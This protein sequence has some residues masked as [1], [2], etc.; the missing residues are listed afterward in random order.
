MKISRRIL[1]V[2]LL[3]SACWSLPAQERSTTDLIELSLGFGFGFPSASELFV[4]RGSGGITQGVITDDLIK[5]VF[6]QRKLVE[7]I[8]L[9]LDYDSDRQGG[10]FDGENIYSLQYLGLEHEF[11]KEISVGNRYLSIPDTRLFPIDEGNT[12]SY[13]LRTALSNDR[14]GIQG[15]IRYSQAL[16]GKKRFRGSSQLVE[17]EALDVNYVKRRFYFLPDRDI[18]ESS[19]LLYSSSEVPKDVVVDGKD[20]SLLV[21][22][23]DY[24]F[25]NS[26][27]RIYLQHALY[28]EDELIVYYEQG[29]SAVGSGLPLGQQAIIDI[30]GVRD[31]F[32]ESGYGVYFGTDGGTSYLYLRK[33]GLDSYW[34]I[35]SAYSLAEVYGDLFPQEVEVKILSTDTGVPNGNYDPLIDSYIVDADYGVLIFT[36]EDGTDFYPRPFPAE[37][38]YD[39]ADAPYAVGDPRNP[40]DPGHPIYDEAGGPDAEDSVNT[41]RISYAVDSGS[42]FL[43]FDII[44]G[45]VRVTVDGQ[46]LTSSQFSVDYYSGTIT[47]AEGV[48][49]PTSD[50]E[51]FY[52]YSPLI[53]GDQELLFALGLDYQLEWLRFRNLTTVDLPL[54]P[55][56]AP[57]LGEERELSFANSTDLTISVGAAPDEQG[58]AADFEVGAAIALH[59]SNHRRLAVV[60]D[61]EVVSLSAYGGDGGSIVDAAAYIT[62]V[63]TE[64]TAFSQQYPDVYTDLHG[65]EEYRS[66]YGSAEQVLVCD[67]DAAGTPLSAGESVYLSRDFGY[68]ADLSEYEQ[69]RIHLYIQDVLTIPAQASFSL[70]LVGSAADSLEIAILGTAVVDGWNEIIVDLTVPYRVRL[71]GS[72]VGQMGQTGSADPVSRISAIR[73][74]VLAAGGDIGAAAAF[75]FWLDEWHLAESRYRGELDLYGETSSGYRGELGLLGGSL[76]LLT[77]PLVSAGF[78]HQDGER[79]TWFA[80][81]DT[82]L[83]RFIPLAVQLGGSREANIGLFGDSTVSLPGGLDELDSEWS[84]THLI[85]IEAILPFLP[86]LEHRYRHNVEQNQ[87]VGLSE[88][89]YL[90]DSNLITGETLSFTELFRY[91]EG[92]VQSYAFTRS[93]LYTDSE[94]LLIDTPPLLM[95]QDLDLTV[96]QSHQGGISYSWAGNFLSLDLSRG[97]SFE[98]D[99]PEAP[100]AL[101]QDY[102]RRLATLFTP[103]PAVHTGALLASRD[104]KGQLFLNLRRQKYLGFAASLDSSF[105]EH[106]FQS[107]AGN[108]DLSVLNELNLS[109]P[110]SPG[111]KGVLELTPSLRRSFSG[112]YSSS[113][114]AIE[115]W[116]LLGQ[117]WGSLLSLP[118]RMEEYA[119]VN[120][121]AGST[122]V[123]GIG[124]ASLET[125]TSLKIRLQDPIW[126]LPSRGSLEFQGQTGR[127]GESYSQSRSIGIGLGRDFLL[128][129]SGRNRISLD[130]GWESGW[131]YAVKVVSH[132]L[133]LDTGLHLVAGLRGRLTAD[134]RFSVKREDQRIGD[135]NLLLFP[136]QPGRE[137]EVSFQPDRETVTSVLGLEYSWDREYDLKRYRMALLLSGDQA[138]GKVG[139]ISHRDRLELENTFLMADRSQLSDTTIEPLRLLFQHN[140]VVTVSNHL[141]LELSIKTIGGVAESITDGKSVY[142]PALGFELRLSAVLTF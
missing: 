83:L 110:F 117:S 115:E 24:S 66:K 96:T 103:I 74:G 63:E 67:F 69:L 138:E 129:R 72:V 44:E 48:I 33:T 86:S 6:I 105:S 82:T 18:D 45:S 127:E 90:F 47:F 20:F 28:E 132:Q 108:R 22:G 50:I 81:L 1:L 7:R 94:S 21:R 19:L 135:E 98:V 85:G 8:F 97:E 78:E 15:L 99:T 64:S 80:G 73:F 126:Y 9:D 139:R 59:N 133:S 60:A 125:S 131:D 65:R 119:A 40:F 121:L 56:L 32:S 26:T 12:S 91:P 88:A 95:E 76:P 122:E 57:L 100:T 2:L 11:L 61:M 36:F 77:D 71:N 106:N 101:G 30:T 37:Q 89:G 79:D 54:E 92:L 114:P 62:H 134:H 4:D 130:G 10:F 102:A 137:G 55:A 25:D 31:D 53:G 23:Q 27:G 123:D 39:P 5:R 34:E 93:W 120:L 70:V 29:G 104:D 109:L 42:Y 75:T 124:Q 111:G 87:E 116:W 17:T 58:L 41:L 49:G 128:A 140:T 118:L 43:D 142:L 14:V 107:A 136:G 16:T 38:P 112:S 46:P 141:D 68:L 51:V 35:K 84:Y 13:A 113:D 52:S 3:G